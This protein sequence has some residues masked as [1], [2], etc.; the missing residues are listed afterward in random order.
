MAQLNSSPSTPGNLFHKHLDLAKLTTPKSPSFERV[1]TFSTA[2]NSIQKIPSTSTMPTTDNLRK[3]SLFSSFALTTRRTRSI[4][5]TPVPCVKIQAIIKKRADQYFDESL[6]QS[7]DS[8]LETGYTV[9]LNKKN[10]KNYLKSE[11][12]E[13]REQIAEIELDI[14][15][16]M[17]KY[18]NLKEEL[19]SAKEQNQKFSE[20][21]Q[22]YLGEIEKVNQ[23]IIAR[24]VEIESS[25]LRYLNI[26]AEIDNEIN[27]IKGEIITNREVHHQELENTKGQIKQLKV[28]KGTCKEELERL[29]G[30]YEKIKSG[31]NDKRRKIENK[32]RM[33]LGLLKH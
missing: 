19:K 13:L 4:A 10:Q 20:G 17:N 9:V 8:L 22:H 11:E 15:P 31:H 16:E 3:G 28:E 24:K 30:Q 1:N 12:E 32:S 6:A 26:I 7:V 23:E 29:K 2:A 33:F 21:V 27:Q 18:F 5:M 25:R 14:L